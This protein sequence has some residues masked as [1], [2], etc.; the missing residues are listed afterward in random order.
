M[1]QQTPTPSSGEPEPVARRP[2]GIGVLDGTFIVRV[3]SRGLTR[4]VRASVEIFVETVER[5]R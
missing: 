4:R 1:P 3:A 5:K 2:V